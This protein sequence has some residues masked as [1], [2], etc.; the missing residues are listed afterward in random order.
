MIAM[1]YYRNNLVNGM[2]YMYLKD[3]KQPRSSPK[4]S[5]I[6]TKSSAIERGKGDMISRENCGKRLQMRWPFAI[7]FWT[8]EKISR[9]RI[10]KDS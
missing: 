6:L 5:T 3:L 7:S 8:E 4:K 2:T 10:T 9:L 1:R